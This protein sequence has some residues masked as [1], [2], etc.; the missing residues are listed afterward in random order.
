MSGKVYFVGAGP[1]DPELLTRKAWAILTLAET[2][3]HDALVAP[4]ILRLVPSGATLCDVGKRCGNKSI[5]QEEIHA[6]L[7]GH[8]SAGKMVVRLQ[9]GDPMIFGRGAEEL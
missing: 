6:L 3:L 9:G 4:D 1:G 2:V 5:T 7:I 8:A